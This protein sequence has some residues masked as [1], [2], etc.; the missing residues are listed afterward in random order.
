MS[1]Y[2]YYE[3]SYSPLLFSIQPWLFVLYGLN[4]P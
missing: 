1:K 2:I 4:E 3:Q